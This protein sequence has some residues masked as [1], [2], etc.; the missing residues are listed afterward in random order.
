V[1]CVPPVNFSEEAAN[2]MASKRILAGALTLALV[3]LACPPRRAVWAA[4]QETP[5][6]TPAEY[7][8]YKAAADEKTPQQR[9]RLL[10]DFVAKFPQSSLLP[11]A[12]QLYYT[13][14]NELKNYPRTVEYA[15]KLLAL[16]DKLD[17]ATR[18]QALYTRAFVF[19]FAY[20]PR[21]PRSREQLTQ[22][23]EAAQQGLQVLSKL[24]KPENVTEEQFAQSKKVISIQFY[25]SAGFAALQLKD[26][27]TSEDQF[28]KVLALDPSLAPTWYRLGVAEL[29]QEPPQYLDGFWALA[30][31]VALK[32]PNE[33]QVRNYLRAQILRYQQT[34]CEKETDRQ[35]NELLALAASSVERPA[36]YRL[37][38]GAELQKAREESVANFW[39]PLKAGGDRAKLVWLALCGLEYPEVPSKVIEV[40]PGNDSVVL[41]LFLAAGSTAEEVEKATTPNME[42]HVAREPRAKLFKKDDVLRFSG[43]LAGY[44]LEPFLLVWE[45]AKVKPE[46]LPEE[47]APAKHPAKH[48]AKRPAKRPRS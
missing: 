10:D 34:A 7:N 4:P 20:N 2:K 17:V 22:A 16:G 25:T 38:S 14:Y 37:P 19:E 3:V 27:K 47:K 9:V 26:Y 30:R 31:A 48:P 28:K 1:N 36:S 11:Y 46:D 24:P 15:D 35:M 21:E 29:Q 5:A 8:A 33:A 45:N 23:V 39:E 18:L 41:K 32:V 6:Y 12:Y 43:T 40:I 13:T 42:V 44:T